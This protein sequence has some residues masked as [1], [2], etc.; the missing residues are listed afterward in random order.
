M[1][2]EQAMIGQCIPDGVLQLENHQPGEQRQFHARMSLVEARIV[3]LCAMH[4]LGAGGFSRRAGMISRDVCG[5]RFGCYK[6]GEVV[7][8]L[9]SDDFRQRFVGALE[10]WRKTWGLAPTA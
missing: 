7:S 1:R 4:A 8:W 2:K 5:A 10:S 9:R 6:P 3:I